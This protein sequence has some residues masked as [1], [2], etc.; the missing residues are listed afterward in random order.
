M[1]LFKYFFTFKTELPSDLPGKMFSPLHLIVMAIL[2][3]ATPLIAWSLRK[4]DKRKMK[5]LFAILWIF[6]VLMEIA[7]DVWSAVLSPYGFEFT[8]NLPLY[9][10]SLFLFIMPFAIWGKE[11]GI[12]KRS[13]CSYL[14]TWNTIGGFINFIYPATVLTD[15]SVISFQGFHTLFYH[16]TMVFVALLM[17][18]SKYYD[19]KNIRDGFLTFL[20]IAFISIPANIVNFNLGC[21]YMFFRGGFVLDPIY[22]SMPAWLFMLL[23]YLIYYFIPF[24]FYLPSFIKQKMQS[25]RQPKLID[26]K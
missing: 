10:C 22:N 11:D 5:I 1:E 19:Y 7:K 23:V 24:L 13:A 17:L 15:Y 21:T 3:I 26:N 6:W 4:M 18:F 14:C 16:A 20:P 8:G 12:L 25:A 2:F 9:V